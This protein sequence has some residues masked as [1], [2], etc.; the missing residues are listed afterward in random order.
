MD[1]IDPRRK[2]DYRQDYLNLIPATGHCNIR[3]NDYW[4]TPEQERDGARLLNPRREID[5][6]EQI[7]ECIE[8]GELIGLTLPAE[9]QIF[10]LDLNDPPLCKE[11]LLRTKNLTLKANGPMLLRADLEWQDA[12]LFFETL[13]E[14]IARL[15]PP[16][17]AA[18]AR[19]VA[20]AISQGQITGKSPTSYS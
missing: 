16:I 20:T 18:T 10:R 6:D 1:H 17:R 13:E 4:P 12:R 2:N 15:I 8:S 11:R 14:N 3:K 9:F 7:V 19:Q 5:Y